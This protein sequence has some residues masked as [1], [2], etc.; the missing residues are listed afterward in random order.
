YGLN[1]DFFKK[2]LF[3]IIDHPHQKT[4]E[5]FTVHSTFQCLELSSCSVSAVD[6]CEDAP[7]RGSGVLQADATLYNFPDMGILPFSLCFS[8]HDYQRAN[9]CLPP[10]TGHFQIA[11]PKKMRA[12]NITI[13]SHNSGIGSCDMS[14]G[15]PLC[16][17][18]STHKMYIA[19]SLVQGLW[20]SIITGPSTKTPL[21]YP[22]VVLSH[23]DPAVTVHRTSPFTHSSMW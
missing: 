9:F 14:S 4:F 21:G 5:I 22:A 6:V 20:H 10:K 11:I 12:A 13:S 7:I 23:G 1:F 19:M 8:F 2:I 3:D 15:T 18:S 17:I 16:P